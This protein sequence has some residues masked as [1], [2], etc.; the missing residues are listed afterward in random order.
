[1]PK[2]SKES[3]QAKREPDNKKDV[4]TPPR[5]ELGTS[6]EI[7]LSGRV[8][9]ATEKVPSW[10]PA[11]SVRQY[12]ASP[13]DMQDIQHGVVTYIDAAGSDT[14]SNEEVDRREEP[15]T[16]ASKTKKHPPDLEM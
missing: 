6:D 8:Y 7:V 14:G 15:Y 3:R 4:Y 1:M 16:V 12:I 9:Y 10:P 5:D 2:R 13:E 11:D